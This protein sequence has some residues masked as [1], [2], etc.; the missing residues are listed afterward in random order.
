M[1]FFLFLQK[2]CYDDSPH[3]DSVSILISQE[4]KILKFSVGLFI[5]STCFCSIWAVS[6]EEIHTVH[7]IRSDVSLKDFNLIEKKRIY[8]GTEHVESYKW[9]DYTIC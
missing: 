8:I 3:C 4:L 7:V 5:Y 2:S 1:K 6:T 9:V